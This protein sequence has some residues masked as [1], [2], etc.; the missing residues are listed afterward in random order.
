MS[1]M[2][3]VVTV[4]TAT[5][6]GV[7]S[8]RIPAP[9]LEQHSPPVRPL[10]WDQPDGPA[11]CDHRALAVVHAY[12]SNGTLGYYVQCRRCGDTHG[13]VAHAKLPPSIKAAAPARYERDDPA[14]TPHRERVDT[15]RRT[16]TDDD[17]QA[18]LAVF[19]KTHAWH[20]SPMNVEWQRTRCFVLERAAHRCEASLAGCIGRASQVHHTTYN[21][22]TD[23]E[24]VGGEPAWTLRAVCRTCHETLHRIP[25]RT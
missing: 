17:R 14:L 13:E 22:N 3:S 2:R 15:A 1:D 25:S 6:N 23:N 20:T 19:R 18:K 9:V 4:V 24:H 7:G 16:R 10:F 5:R 21:V 12:K 8:Q 11:E